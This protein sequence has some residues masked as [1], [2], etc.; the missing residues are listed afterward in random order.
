MPSEIRLVK[1][2]QMSPAEQ[3]QE[4]QVY[5]A[6][7]ATWTI[8]NSGM[9]V[10]FDKATRRLVGLPTTTNRT[11]VDSNVRA[12]QYVGRQGTPP[13]EVN[14]KATQPI[15]AFIVDELVAQTNVVKDS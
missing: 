11:P 4:I 13:T 15:P 9:G 5:R 7:F 12:V 8:G 6:Y 3:E 10:M 14:L 1:G 2:F